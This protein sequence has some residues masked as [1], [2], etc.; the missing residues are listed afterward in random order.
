VS[1]PRRISD[2]K[3]LFTNLAQTSHYEVQFGGLS[4][5]L[6]IYLSG[7]GVDS[8]FISQ[9]V[10]LLCS[11]TTLPTHSL[12]TSDIFNYIGVRESFAHTKIFS[13]I[14]MDFY[15]DSSY[16]V[17]KFVEHWMEFISSGSHNPI[18]G[19]SPPINQS[20][21]AYFVRMQYP[22]YYKSDATRIIKFDRDYNAEIEYTFFGLY[23][24]SVSSP[25]V[26]Y[27]S[28]NILTVSVSFQFDRY[29]MGR[30]NSLSEYEHSDNNK[31]PT[32]ST[33][34]N[35][36]LPNKLATGRQEMIWRNL[37][38]GTGRLDDP[39]PRGVGGPYTPIQP[40]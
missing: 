7:R 21:P 36:V 10:G 17:L 15:V 38:E 14:S 23:P 40:I 3:P 34:D 39:R 4:R 29:V 13:Q 33:I 19:V 12:G 5:E 8:R 35:S 30:I 32:T 24:I 31:I 25:L 9:D 16:N 18:D 22:E 20:N 37:N 28:S 27:S 26:S 1:L 2:I 11:S 6:L